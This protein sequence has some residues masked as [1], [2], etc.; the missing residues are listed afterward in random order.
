IVNN[1]ANFDCICWFTTVDGRDAFTVKSW[2]RLI[3]LFNSAGFKVGQELS[4][5]KNLADYRFEKLNDRRKKIVVEEVDSSEF[6]DFNSDDSKESLTDMAGDL[7]Y[8]RYFRPRNAK[9][10]LVVRRSPQK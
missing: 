3:K 8:H 5:R 1:D 7:F 4:I 9:L 6:S 10:R 2:S